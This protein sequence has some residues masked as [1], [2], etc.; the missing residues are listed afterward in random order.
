MSLSRGCGELHLSLRC[1]DHETV[2]IDSNRHGVGIEYR[3]NRFDISYVIKSATVS[4]AGLDHIP[5]FA[6]DSLTPVPPGSL[7]L[8]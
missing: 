4:P 2:L 8:Q 1:G 5:L 6:L 7:S 3:L